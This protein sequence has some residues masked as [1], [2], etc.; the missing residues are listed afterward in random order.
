ML[1]RP[2]P[3]SRHR[4]RQRA[5]RQRQVAGSLMM[6][7]ELGPDDTAKLYWLGHLRDCELEDR[8]AIA[9]AIRALLASIVMDA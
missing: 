5:Y 1:E 3:P 2:S 9:T 4:A 8:R 7:V 6:T